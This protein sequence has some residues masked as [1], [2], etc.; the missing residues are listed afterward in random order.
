M[1]H[2]EP[3]SCQTVAPHLDRFSLGVLPEGEESVVRDHLEA[4][5]SCRTLVAR[6]DPSVLFL[7]MRGHQLPDSFWAGFSD[8]LRA[9]LE[10]AR[11]RWSDLF[12]YPRLAYLTAPAA[13]ALI[14]AVTLFVAESGRIRVPGQAGQQ[15][16]GTIPGVDPGRIA[17][18][19]VAGD[20]VALLGPPV[21][22]EVGLPEARVY[23]FD[24]GEGSDP[25]PIFLV[26]DESINI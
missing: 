1:S 22:E 20:P 15:L 9:G 12:R 13:L 11:F 26:F 7:E 23:R 24:V 16:T 3:K 8:R 10:P 17:D 2:H 6:Q 21:L 4:C 19:M 18:G 25:T 5:S 14:L